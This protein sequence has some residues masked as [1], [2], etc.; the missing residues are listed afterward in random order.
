MNLHIP[1]GP[2]WEIRGPSGTIRATEV[3]AGPQALGA[4]TGV[5]PTEDKSRSEVAVTETN[6]PSV[7]SS[8]DAGTGPRASPPLSL[9]G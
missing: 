4:R 7:L 3:K 5:A 1:L 2:A 6:R 9:G 8:Q